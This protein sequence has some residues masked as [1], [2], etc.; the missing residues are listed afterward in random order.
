MYVLISLADG[1]D[2]AMLKSVKTNLIK[3]PWLEEKE[4]TWERLLEIIEQSC[5]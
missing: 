2:F 3:I 4:M 1:Y 5:I